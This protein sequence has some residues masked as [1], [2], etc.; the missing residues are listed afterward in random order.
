MRPMDLT[1]VAKVRVGGEG[2]PVGYM[3]RFVE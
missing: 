3:V 1:P 2:H